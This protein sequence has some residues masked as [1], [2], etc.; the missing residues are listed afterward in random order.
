[1]ERAILQLDCC[2]AKSSF[3][4]EYLMK[5]FLKERCY[6][7]NSVQFIILNHVSLNIVYN[8]V[9]SR[10]NS[11]SISVSENWIGMLKNIER[12]IIISLLVR[13]D[14]R[15]KPIIMLLLT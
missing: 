10:T 11:F 8:I 5:E 12:G 1:M 7:T 13:R 2:L 14:L 9:T 3:I 6:I 4:T 15:N